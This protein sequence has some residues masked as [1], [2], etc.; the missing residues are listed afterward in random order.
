MPKK[1]EDKFYL[2]PAVPRNTRLAQYLEQ[3]SAQSGVTKSQLLV[4]FASEYVRLVV[5]G[6]GVVPTAPVTVPVISTTASSEI[7]S[8]QEAQGGIR[9]LAS[10]STGAD[11]NFE[12]FGDPD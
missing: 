10:L 12:S 4:V 1:A 5:D 3:L 11:A 2:N 8:D 7:P 9:T 6:G